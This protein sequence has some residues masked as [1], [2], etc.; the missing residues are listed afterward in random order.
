MIAPDWLE[1][2]D[3]DPSD[4]TAVPLPIIDHDRFGFLG[5]RVN[6][7]TAAESQ[8]LPGLVERLAVCTTADEDR[9][10]PW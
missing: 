6:D 3:R 10:R 1:M 4:F 7:K 2:L 8:S 5:Y 9:M